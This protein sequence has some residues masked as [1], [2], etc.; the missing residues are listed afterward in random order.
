MAQYHVSG[1][2]HQ[3]GNNIRIVVDADDEA[4]A[5]SIAN[6]RGVLVSRI[7]RAGGPSNLISC[8]DCGRQ[9]SRLAA[10]CPACG[11]PSERKRPDGID[12]HRRQ[13]SDWNRLQR[14]I[15]KGYT[16]ILKIYTSIFARAMWC[17]S[18]G[19]RR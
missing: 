6:A 11:R 13:A 15:N 18:K 4:E 14:A 19:V 17:S 8:P 12:A 7:E 3:T 1:A 10:A 2:D 16:I 5:L 9:I